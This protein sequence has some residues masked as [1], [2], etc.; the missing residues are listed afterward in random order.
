[1]PP[2]SIPHLMSEITHRLQIKYIQRKFDLDNGV[3]IKF[4]LV[5]VHFVG[6]VLGGAWIPK[7]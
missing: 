2:R 5:G 6:Y 7:A 4:A 3:K 1:V